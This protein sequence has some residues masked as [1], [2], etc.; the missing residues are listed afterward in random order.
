MPK[1]SVILP[2]YN[3]SRYLKDSVPSVM[4]QTFRDFELLIIDDGSTDQTKDVIGGYR[5]D[6]RFI[7]TKQQHAGLS[8][9]R[10]RGLESAR[11]EYIAFIDCDDIFL[12]EKLKRQVQAFDKNAVAD[13]VYTSE[14][15]FYD[16]EEERSFPSPYEKLSGDLLFFLKRSN[17][18]HISTI[19]VR[20]DLL[21][22]VRFDPLLKS[23]EDWD[24]LLRISEKGALFY[25]IPE[26][27]SLIRIRK[28]SMTQETGI[29][30]SSR[31]LVGERAK[32]IWHDLKRSAGLTNPDGFNKLV[33]YAKLKMRA[34]LLGFP[35]A[36]KFNRPAPS[37]DR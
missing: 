13:V 8:E 26:E 17:F 1:V 2:T 32:K 19:M 18:I 9:A 11:G 30:D 25:Y 36:P 16:G 24:F 27:L 6:P 15:F 12:K 28:G 4:S 29:M 7:Y 14:R 10:N 22:D 31:D 3:G 35:D 34:R 33:R 20:K 37:K 21:R 23:H 5:S